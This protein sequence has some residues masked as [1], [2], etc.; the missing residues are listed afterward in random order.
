[1]SAESRLAQM[2]IQLPPAPR[3]IGLYR[4]LTV[5][6]S[7]AF[8]AGHGPLM[9]DGS[10]ITGRV[11]DDLD[12]AQG[13]AAARQTGL[14][15]LATLRQQLGSLDRV[16]RLV[17]LLGMVRCTPEFSQQPA[18]INGCSQ[19]LAELFGEDQGIAARSA[20]GVASLPA[21]MAIEIEAIFEIQP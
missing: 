16:V 21:E 12:V 17:K 20:V 6:G 4:P 11:G 13:T 8:T 7:L 3:P 19:L 14:A 9:P 5:C 10:L 1:M 18:V 15:I 2:Q